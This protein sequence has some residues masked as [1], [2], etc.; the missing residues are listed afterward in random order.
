MAYHLCYRR[1]NVLSPL[2]HLSSRPT[3]SLWTLHQLYL[4]F[5]QL[6][7]CRG[8][9]EKKMTMNTTHIAM[10][11]EYLLLEPLPSRLRVNLRHRRIDHRPHYP[12]WY[13]LCHR[14]EL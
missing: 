2:H 9:L 12:Q 13:L 14:C 8:I 7:H 4:R 3:E 1:Y 6:L 11:G 5:S 10:L